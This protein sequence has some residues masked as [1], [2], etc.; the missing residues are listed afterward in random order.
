MKKKELPVTEKL[1][2]DLTTEERAN[3]DAIAA[4]CGRLSV[5]A[6][7]RMLIAEKWQGMSAVRLVVAG[8]LSADSFADVRHKDVQTDKKSREPEPTSSAWRSDVAALRA[9]GCECP[10]PLIGRWPGGA[11]CCR[12]C[13]RVAGSPALSHAPVEDALERHASPPLQH[14]VVQKPKPRAE[15]EAAIARAAAEM[16]A[17]RPALAEESDDWGDEDEHHA[18]K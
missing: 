6:A 5:G 16:Q 14:P 10:K 17:E 13:N 1:T 12:L 2:I 15:I 18:E 3:L 9:A 4:S 11:P 8:Q 7:V